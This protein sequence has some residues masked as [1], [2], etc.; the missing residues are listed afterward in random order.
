[1]KS[2]GKM[3]VITDTCGDLPQEI[4]K[5]YPIFCVPLVVACGARPTPP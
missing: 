4:F 1:M 3:A 5:D 2:A